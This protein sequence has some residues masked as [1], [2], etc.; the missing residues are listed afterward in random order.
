[1]IEGKVK[2]FIGLDKTE[3]PEREVL[4]FDIETYKWEYNQE[5]S[6]YMAGGKLGNRVDPA[7]IKAKMEE[8]KEKFALSP[9][10]GQIILCGFYD[11]KDY[12]IF[13]GTE[14][15][16]IISS[17]ELIG[18]AVFNGARLVSK[19]GKRFDLPYLL[20]R[21]VI[22]G[23]EPSINFTFGKLLKKYD[24]F[25][26]IDFEELLDGTLFQWGYLCGIVNQFENPAS[27]IG[28]WYE[29]GQM[30]TIIEKNKEDLLITHKL[31]ER[32]KW[33]NL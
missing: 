28:Q 16:I 25:Y 7:K 14:E 31:Y 4:C 29:N 13:Q 2:E 18:G 3:L 1:M 17:L 33:A 24:T 19:A 30:D 20:Q 27:E 11:G 6:D 26:H 32:L 10:T 9:L 15:E 22:L 21:A 12:T 5:F 23:L 8:N